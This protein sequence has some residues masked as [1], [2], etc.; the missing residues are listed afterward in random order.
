MSYN[1]VQNGEI[2]TRTDATDGTV[3][4]EGFPTSGAD[5]STAVFAIR[6]RVLVGT[7]WTTSWAGAGRE[8]KFLWSA[9]ATDLGYTE[10]VEIEK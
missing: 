1:K 9:R 2:P 3:I 5:L 10:I 6:K 8:K 4:Y 7:V